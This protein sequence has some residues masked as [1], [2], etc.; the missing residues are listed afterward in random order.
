MD[1]N[2]NK[3]VLEAKKTLE[4][5]EKNKLEECRKDIEAVLN[6]HGYDMRVAPATIVLV[7][8]PNER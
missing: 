8:R 6:K 4:E 7:K 3:A 5:Y 2:G 1:E